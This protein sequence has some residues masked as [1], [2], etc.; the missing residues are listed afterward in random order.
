MASQT[1]ATTAVA[2]NVTINTTPTAAVTISNLK[3][4]KII[5]TVI[6]IEYSTIMDSASAGLPANYEL[7]TTSIKGKK[8]KTTRLAPSVNF[9]QSTNTVTLTVKGK[10]NAFPTVACSRSCHRRT[11]CAARQGS[12]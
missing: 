9:V 1:T 10:K 5:S 3:I 6:T 12:S 2:P 4:K 7:F 11:A 8:K